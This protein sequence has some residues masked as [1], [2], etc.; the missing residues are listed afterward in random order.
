MRSKAKEGAGAIERVSAKALFHHGS[1]EE[2]E[3]IYG[4]F[5]T[6]IVGGRER[7]MW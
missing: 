5:V 6:V 2:T 4:C 3:G 1:T 7:I